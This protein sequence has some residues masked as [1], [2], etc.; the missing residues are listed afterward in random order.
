MGKAVLGF[1]SIATMTAAIL[2]LLGY[3]ASRDTSFA[4]FFDTNWEMIL[5]AT[6]MLV[7]GLLIVGGGGA[8]LVSV[9]GSF[10]PLTVPISLAIMGGG[11]F[12]V[13]L[14]IKAIIDM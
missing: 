10:A 5:L 1:F 6:G 2:T 4:D 12:L 3:V 7:F 11:G 13:Y 8:L 14:G 9:D